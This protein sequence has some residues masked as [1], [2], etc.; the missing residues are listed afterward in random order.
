MTRE[1]KRGDIYWVDF[2]L[3][4][5]SEQGGVRPAVIIQNNIGNK[6]SPTVIVCPITSRF[7]K[8]ELPTHV[9]I[10][11][12]KESGL[13]EESQVLTEQISTKDKLS[14]TGYIGTI[15]KETMKEI[16]KA[17]E[18]SVQVGN[19]I[20]P[21]ER[22]EIKVIKEKVDEIKSLDRFIRMWLNYNN[23]IDRIQNY[24]SDREIAIKDL[25]LYANRFNLNYKDFYSPLCDEKV[26]MVG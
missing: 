3:S 20:N 18:I 25:E 2:G 17:I 12:Y 24:I 1:I 15:D 23:D 4:T 6:F 10:R 16:D 22:R 11:N 7:K 26:R 14:I 5:G 19:A 9:R 8:K 13:L 21:I